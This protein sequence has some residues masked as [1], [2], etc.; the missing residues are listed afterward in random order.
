[1][2]SRAAQLVVA[3][4]VGTAGLALP[5][6]QS[7]QP[8]G[9][10]D[11]YHVHFTQAVPG[12]AAA[13]GKALLSPDPSSPMPDHFVVFRH[14]EG[15]EWDYLVIQHLGPK[16]TVD[17][18]P[19]GPNPA[20]DLRAWHTDTFASGPSWAE[21]SRA[22]GIGASESS[23][24]AV[25][26][27]SP[28]RAVP[29][30]RDQLGKLLMQAPPSA[31]KVQTG[32][33]LLQHLEGGDWTFLSLTRYDSWQDLAT[34]RAQAATQPDAEGGWAEIR[35]HSQGHRDTIADRIK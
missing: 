8:S 12:Q 25:Y 13:L 18:A 3:L 1:M 35:Q 2:K 7:A 19:A 20:R 16:A 24:R 5:Q 33:V 31:S 29:G 17:P 32:N 34:D 6:A 26:I 9:S 11:V 23:G 22:L 10:T 30:H 27:I 4:G 15:D 28:H 21:F 14:Q